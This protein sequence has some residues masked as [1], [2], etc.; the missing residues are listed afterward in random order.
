MEYIFGSRKDTKLSLAGERIM[1]EGCSIMLDTEKR[2]HKMRAKDSLLSG[3]V[4]KPPVTLRENGEQGGWVMQLELRGQQQAGERPAW[5]SRHCHEFEGRAA[6]CFG[7]W[8]RDGPSQE[9]PPFKRGRG[10]GQATRK[11][12]QARQSQQPLQQSWESGSQK[13]GSW[14]P[15][16]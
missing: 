16:D 6:V 1:K 8:V 14:D 13:P 2:W 3:V 10:V 5:A 11:R 7:E 15:R 4:G 12:T 9:R